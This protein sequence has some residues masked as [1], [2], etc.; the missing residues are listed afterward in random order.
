MRDHLLTNL[1]FGLVAYCR[2]RKPAANHYGLKHTQQAVLSNIVAAYFL[3]KRKEATLP[4][5]HPVSTRATQLGANSGANFSART[6]APKSRHSPA[7]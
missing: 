7:H 2:A 5:Y 1:R 4:Q 6:F 3:R